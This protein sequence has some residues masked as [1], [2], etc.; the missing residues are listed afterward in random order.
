MFYFIINPRS[1][2]GY[3]Q[4]VW[5]RIEAR[6]IEEQVEYQ[7]YLTEY[8]GHAIKIT[9][10]ITDTVMTSDRSPRTI[11]VLG[12]DGTLNEVLN[13]LAFQR[14]I[15]LGYIPTGSGNDFARSMKIHNNPEKAFERILHPKYYRVLD[16]GVVSAGK[17]EITH[18]RFA[19]SA[20]IGYD[21]AVCHNVSHAAIKKP[22]NRLK[23]GK[24]IYLMIGLKQILCT[25]PSDGTLVLDGVKK[26]PLKQMWFCSFH[27][28][29]Y[30]GGGFI[31]AP[32]AK[33]DDGKLCIC[34]VQNMPKYKFVAVL[35][36]SLI[37]KH[38]HFRGVN[39]YECKEADLS[40][41]NPM[42]M[43]TDGESFYMQKDLSIQCINKKLRLIV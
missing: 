14:S 26:I 12:G 4:K 37:G 24:Q 39:F 43:H 16:Y 9:E 29:R 40:V 38:A 23:L 6:L 31:F 19:V 34:V 20:G 22:L 15:T 1:R 35:A 36:A 11:I 27:I 17:E 21:A 13:G 8:A 28:H 10:E 25:R 41:E 33:P 3:G 32:K 2:A 18:R 30:E 42:A 7:A 5:N